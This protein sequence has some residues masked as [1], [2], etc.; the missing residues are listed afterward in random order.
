MNCVYVELSCLFL[1][2]AKQ[3]FGTFKEKNRMLCRSSIFKMK[4]TSKDKIINDSF[5]D[6][7]EKARELKKAG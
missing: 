1:H 7:L 6:K 2:L 4:L 3:I 5:D